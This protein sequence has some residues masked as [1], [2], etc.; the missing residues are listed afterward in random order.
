VQHDD[1]DQRIAEVAGDGYRLVEKLDPLAGVYY[2]QL[3][4]QAG[5]CGPAER[6]LRRGRPG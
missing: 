5:R 1:Q 3:G 4:A 2:E 6:R